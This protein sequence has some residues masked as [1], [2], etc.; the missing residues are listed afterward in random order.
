VT[1]T[2]GETAPERG[3]GGDDTSWAG[4]NLIGP[5]NEKILCSQFN[6]YK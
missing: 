4:A 2:G 6:C 1:S 3:K 5:K